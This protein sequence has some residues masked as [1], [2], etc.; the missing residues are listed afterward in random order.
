MSRIHDALKKAAQDRP[1]PPPSD[2]AISMGELPT[3]AQEWSSRGSLPAANAATEAIAIATMPTGYLR[4]EDLQANCAQPA[5]HPDPNSNVFFNPNLN[6]HAAEQFRT[7]RSRLY[8][9][10]E[11]QNLRTLLITSSVLGEGKTFVTSNLAQSI[12]RQPDRRVVIIDADLRCARLHSMLGAP[13]S[14]GLTEYLR[15]EADEVQIIQ[16]GPGG[17][18]CLIPGGQEVPNPSELLMNGRLKNLLDRIG[19]AFDWV[20]FDSP[21]CVTVAD[22]S[23]LAR[24]CD[25]VLLV[26]RA[27]TTPVEVAQKACQELKD[28]NL[29]GAVLNATEDEH[30]YGSYYAQGYGYVYGSGPDRASSGQSTAIG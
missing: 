16:R 10:R 20:I 26:V 7:L 27:T 15:G 25:G 24:Y 5:W 13:P 18:I 11:V 12:V 28:R 21:P 3:A 8:Q 29:V 1:A 19:P 2:A 17:N 4:F 30:F 6:A 23:I 22:A 9:I 14:P